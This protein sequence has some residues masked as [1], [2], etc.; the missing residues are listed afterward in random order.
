MPRN[1][2]KSSD[3]KPIGTTTKADGTKR[4]FVVEKVSTVMEG[5]TK[6]IVFQ[7]LRHPDGR[8]QYRFGYYMLGAK[9]E[10]KDRWR[11]VRN[12]PQIFPEHLVLLLQQAASEGW[13]PN[14]GDA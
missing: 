9:D 3:G 14:P 13:Y 12:T 2:D 5:D 8:W 7:L 1:T 4:H 10:W 6:R 11:W